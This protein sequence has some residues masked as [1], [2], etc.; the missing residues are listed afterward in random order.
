MKLC[1]NS[2]IMF[3]YYCSR[4]TNDIKDFHTTRLMFI[5]MK[6]KKAAAFQLEM[7]RCLLYQSDVTVLF[8]FFFKLNALIK[9]IEVN[10]NF[11][12]LFEY[13]FG[14]STV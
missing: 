13:I 9:P 2:R 4:Y 12:I 8:F 10:V 3:R 1:I 6:P 14:R 7:K 5:M 11:I